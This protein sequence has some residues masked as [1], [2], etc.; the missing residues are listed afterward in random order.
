MIRIEFVVVAFC[1]VVFVFGFVFFFLSNI[2]VFH[3]IN[4]YNHGDCLYV[5]K[6]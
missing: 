2:N 6:V 1:C 4:V 3:Y 5:F